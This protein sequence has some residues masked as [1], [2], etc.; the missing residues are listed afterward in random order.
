[1]QFKEKLEDMQA[2]INSYLNSIIPRDEAYINNLLDSMRYSLFA[3]GKRMRPIL[4]L[5]VG[6]IFDC[7]AEFILPFAAAVEMIHTYSLIHDD[8]PAIDNDDYRRGKLTNHKVYGEACA[9]LSGDA[10][11]NFAYEHIL[12]FSLKY[13]D[14]RFIAASY[15][16]SKAA[17][18]YGM[19]GGQ[20]VDIE[21]E[22]KPCDIKTV[23]YMHKNKTGALITAS[24]RSSA[25]I[26]RVNA[27]DLTRL[28]D[29]A[30]K[31]GLAFQI[32]DDILDV[33]GDDAKLGKKHGSDLKSN[34][35]TY[36]SLVGLKSSR[37]MAARLTN[38]ALNL[39]SF[40]KEKAEFLYMLTE[41]LLNREY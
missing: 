12:D 34:K 7:K 9:I 22:N 11:L 21:N 38:D 28:T 19:I 1:M 8:L 33:V 2:K 17:G 10:L 27:D 31:L 30:Q 40:Y 25:V 15:E 23:E 36:V 4:M 5:T 18:I 13:N 32:I 24:V 41:Y 20:V 35:S 3:G 6:E 16:I 37:E 14:T 26:S 39:I 29:F